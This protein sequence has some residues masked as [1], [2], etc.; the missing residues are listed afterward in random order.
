MLHARSREVEGLH[1]Y[2]IHRIEEKLTV[3]EEPIHLT[4]QR[5]RVRDLG[6]DALNGRGWAGNEGGARVDGSETRIARGNGSGL[7]VYL[8]GCE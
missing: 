7:S 4:S 3:G 5:L 1:Q 8:N 2:I 6:E